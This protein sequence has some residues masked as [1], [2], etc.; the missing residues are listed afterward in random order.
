MDTQYG[1]QMGISQLLGG[2]TY[3]QLGQ[4][5]PQMY[6]QPTTQQL[7]QLYPLMSGMFSQYGQQTM[8]PQT[9]QPQ[10]MQPFNPT[11]A[12]PLPPAQQPGQA[13]AMLMAAQGQPQQV[14]TQAS[15]QGPQGQ[16][17]TNPNFGP[18]QA[19]GRPFIDPGFSPGQGTG[20][21]TRP[22]QPT[23]TTPASPANTQQVGIA[24]MYGNRR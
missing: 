9:M 2:Q 10:T 17:F 14:A 21:F 22:S 4:A 12:Q 7:G 15:A 1:S 8:Q 18:T 3:P 16:P 23:T 24:Q 13:S 19:Q 5:Y 20:A 11:L 6:P